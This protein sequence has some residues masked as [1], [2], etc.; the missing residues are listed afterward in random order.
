MGDFSEAQPQGEATL[1]RREVP[2]AAWAFS[3]LRHPSADASSPEAYGPSDGLEG[4]KMEK[5]TEN[6]G[7]RG[8]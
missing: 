5:K 4:K 7:Q 2:E 8:G 6:R 3:E 1:Y